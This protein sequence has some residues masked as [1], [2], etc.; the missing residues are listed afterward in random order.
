MLGREAAR[1]GGVAKASPV[2]Q[3]KSL[4]C[5]IVWSLITCIGFFNKPF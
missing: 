5:L 2:S 1:E 3:Q 4:W